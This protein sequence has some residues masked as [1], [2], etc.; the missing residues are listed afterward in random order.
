VTSRAP[1]A[2]AGTGAQAG[3]RSLLDLVLARAERDPW[4]PAVLRGP[5][6][7]LTYEGLLESSRRVAWAL[8]GAGV[9][10][11]D[12]VAAAAS[13]SGRAVPVILGV[14][15][16]GAVYVPLD[17]LYPDPMLARIAAAVRPGAIIVDSGAGGRP[18]AGLGPVLDA[19]AALRWAGAR[20]ALPDVSSDTEAYVMFTSGSTGAPKGVVLGHAGLRDYASAVAARVGLGPGDR[21]LGGAPLG[22]SSSIRQLLV[23]LTAGAAVV[24]V[25]DT[26]IRTPWRFAE[27]LEEEVVTHLDLVPSFWA[28]LIDALPPA[29]LSAGL[30]GLRRHLFASERLDRALVGRTAAVAPATARIWNL[31][32]CTETTGIVAAHDATGEAGDGGVT[33]I[34]RP[35][36]HVRVE[37]R[38]AGDAGR[39]AGGPGRLV[40]HGTAVAL[41][42]L[43]DGGDLEPLPSAPGGG[44]TLDTGD[45]V[46]VDGDG[47]LVWLGRAN[48]QSKIRG[49]RVAHEAVE[50]H[51]ERCPDVMRA[52]VV[53]VEADRLVAAV[54]PRRP[55]LDSPALL[56]WLRERVPEHMVPG[57]IRS[58]ETWPLLPNGKTDHGRLLELVGR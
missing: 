44:R 49:F 16:A 52:A 55:P 17:P 32:G 50:W 34:G 40:V 38:P 51:L 21:C 11:G 25:D 8:A 6:G 7:P 36:D 9:R 57:R 4:A 26:E 29:Q 39:E 13:R 14:L 18:P 46:E 1:V 30:A 53:G 3:A 48:R 45:L 27:I 20:P 43:A 10:P 35:L 15:L 47:R 5:D 31:F 58:V 41:G 37:V 19:A 22:F 23:P 24:A 12:R 56:R 33:P 2:R 28:A 54:K 42:Y